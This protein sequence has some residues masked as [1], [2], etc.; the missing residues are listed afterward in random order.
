MTVLLYAPLLTG[1]PQVYC[2]VLSDLLL[3]A[4]HVVAVAAGSD[5]GS[6]H[7]DWRDLRPLREATGFLFIDTRTYASDGNPHLSA[8]QLAVMQRD[9]G[10]DST[11]FIEG[12]WFREQF[13]RIARG[14]AQLRGRTTG[15]FSRPCLWFPGEDPYSGL[16]TRPQGLAPLAR[17]RRLRARLFMREATDDFFYGEVLCGKQVVDT[18]L[19]KDERVAE[20]SDGAMCWMPEIYRVLDL[21]PEECRGDDWGRHAGPIQDY[22]CRAGAQNVVL[23]FGKGTRYKGYDYFLKLVHS[24]AAA[25]GL[26]VGAPL[27]EEDRSAMVFDVDDIRQ[28]LLREGRLYETGEF[29]ESADLVSLAFESVSRFVSTHRLTLSS[30]T[31]LQALE[32][33]NP[34]LTPGTGLVGH[35]TVTHGLGMTYRYLDEHDMLDQWQQ[36]RHIENENSGHRIREFM[37]R[38][39]REAV[40]DTFLDALVK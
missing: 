18:V 3:G 24:D 7:D 27:G 12:D 29:I 28:D 4:G 39:S 37:S 11:L 40:T 5:A 31:M 36:F 1:H 23:Y 10:I 38:F 14:E 20:H 2:R 34:V 17:A 21:R 15:I 30:G 13:L 22:V 35:R 26:H 6:W 9:H 33:G 32:C 16:S 19:V 25:C 8:E